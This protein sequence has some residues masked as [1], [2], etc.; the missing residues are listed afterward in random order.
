MPVVALSPLS[1]P[2]L[3]PPMTLKFAALRRPAACIQRYVDATT[4]TAGV[5]ETL[6]HTGSG[7]AKAHAAPLG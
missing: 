6:E 2:L 4:A 1:V 3:G 5:A 7:G